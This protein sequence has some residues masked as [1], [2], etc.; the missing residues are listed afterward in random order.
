MNKTTIQ[1]F[2]EIMEIAQ[3]Y[4]NANMCH[5]EIDES[6]TDKD[7]LRVIELCAEIRRDNGETG[8]QAVGDSLCAKDNLIYAIS[9]QVRLYEHDEINYSEIGTELSA[10]FDRMAREYASTAI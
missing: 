8:E 9:E 5:Q 7:A 1:N 6:T 2:F 10:D 4:H 3:K